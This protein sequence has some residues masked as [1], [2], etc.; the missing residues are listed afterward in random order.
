[1]TDLLGIGTGAPGLGKPDPSPGRCALVTVTTL[2]L[3]PD[4]QRIETTRTYRWDGYTAADAR[5]YRLTLA[6]D[7][8]RHITVDGA[9]LIIRTDSNGWDQTTRYTYTDGEVTA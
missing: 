4:G 1:M 2:R 9:D 7:N 5:H 3:F 8:G 6:R